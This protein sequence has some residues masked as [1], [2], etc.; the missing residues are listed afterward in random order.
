MLIACVAVTMAQVKT[1]TAEQKA[2]PTREVTVQ[3]GE[4]AHVSGND[5]II[6][7]ENGEIPHVTVSCWERGV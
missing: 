7:M 3:R 2:R 5:L 6:K 4:V 1:Q